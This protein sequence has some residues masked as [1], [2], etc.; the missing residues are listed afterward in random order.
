MNQLELPEANIELEKQTI[1]RALTLVSNITEGDINT[2]N[3]EHRQATLWNL[4]SITTSPQIKLA[5]AILFMAFFGMTADEVSAQVSLPDNVTPVTETITTNTTV[6]SSRLRREPYGE[7]L[8]SLPFNQEVRVLGFDKETRQWAYIDYKDGEEPDGFVH[9]SL[10]D[11]DGFTEAPVVATKSITMSG[12]YCGA[13]GQTGRDSYN[14]LCS[15]QYPGTTIF[16]AHNYTNFGKTILGLSSNI[17]AKVTVN[18]DGNY[19]GEYEVV[20]SH[21]ATGTH[22]NNI[23]S[24]DALNSTDNQFISFVTTNPNKQAVDTTARIVVTLRLI[25]EE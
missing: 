23:I 19:L 9:I 11:L 8:G 24:D 17:G 20:N 10:L 22:I 13:E 5:I 18:V 15:I 21:E 7:V 16:Y 14:D 6:N 12:I 3:I 1:T 4:L 2:G 25:V